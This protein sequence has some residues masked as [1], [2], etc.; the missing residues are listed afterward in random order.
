MKKNKQ[1]I[2]RAKFLGFL[3]ISFA[4]IPAF[5]QDVSG[6]SDYLKATDD[7]RLISLATQINPNIYLRDNTDMKAHGNTTP[8]VVITDVASIPLLY[9]DRTD[10]GNVELLKIRIDT[11][12]DEG[13]KLDL[14]QLTAFSNLKYVLYVYQYNSCGDNK[15]TCLQAKTES[16]V[17]IPAGS[18]VKVF[19]LLS[20]PE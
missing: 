2:Y 16:K 7:S 19:Y 15:D 8:T 18:T 4:A 5:G 9:A 11:P 14:M 10:Y 1:T 12:T 13:V 3:L 20:I 6:Y 17:N